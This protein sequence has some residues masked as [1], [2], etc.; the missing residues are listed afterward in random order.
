MESETAEAAWYAHVSWLLYPKFPFILIQ[1]TAGRHRPD[2]N[3]N[4]CTGSG[5]ICWNCGV[6]RTQVMPQPPPPH[7]GK[8]WI[9]PDSPFL[10]KGVCL[11][12]YPYKSGPQTLFLVSHAAWQMENLHI[13]EYSPEIVNVCYT[14]KLDRPTTS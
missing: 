1:V 13:Q 11:L 10:S 2:C 12:D 4:T 3:C 7:P 9:H 6:P 5:H 8:S 14:N